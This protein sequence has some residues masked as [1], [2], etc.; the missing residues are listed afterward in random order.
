LYNSIS[1]TIEPKC[2]LF[3]IAASAISS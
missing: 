3:M 1:S 2:R